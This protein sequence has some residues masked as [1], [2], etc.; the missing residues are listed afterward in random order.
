MD[1]NDN[2]AFLKIIICQLSFIAGLILAMN[3]R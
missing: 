3:I 2:N 1:R